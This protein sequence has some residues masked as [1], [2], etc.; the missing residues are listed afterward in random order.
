MRACW[1]L[2]IAM[3]AG[4][5]AR[6]EECPVTVYVHSGLSGP[7][8][9][10]LYRAKTQAAAMFREIGVTIRWRMGTARPNAADDGCGAPI[11]V[12]IE[13]TATARV[14]AEALACAT[15]YA[16]SGTRI[17]V[18]ADRVARVTEGKLTAVVLSHV[19][20]HEI[21][22]VL[23]QVSRHSADGVM[24]A[25]WELSDY[26]RMELHRLSF[27]AQD[28]ELIHLGMARRMHRVLRAS[29]E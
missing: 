13:E 16:E 20:A 11:E 24:K 6:A 9:T 19:L 2:G 23:E 14:S 27:A 8:V 17:H 7:N 26:R 22:H 5:S 25:H 18:F 12:S 1:I 4:L 3:A 10:V 28:V 15:P 29:A 21:T